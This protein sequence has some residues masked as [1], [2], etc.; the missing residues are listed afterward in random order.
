MNPDFLGAF[1]CE[2]IL[3]NM[4]C[5]EDRKFASSITDELK[6][7]VAKTCWPYY[8]EYLADHDWDFVNLNDAE[9]SETDQ[10]DSALAYLTLV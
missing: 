4:W 3:D 6:E 1:A 8:Q 7:R 10:R 5:L 2:Q 9:I